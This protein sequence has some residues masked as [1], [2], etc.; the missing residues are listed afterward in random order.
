[1]SA[2]LSERF[3][4]RVV[5][6]TGGAS[7]IGQETVAAFAREGARVA[8]AFHPDHEHN[9]Q[10]VADDLRSEGLDVTAYAAD[11]GDEQ[12]FAE[13]CEAVRDEIG[14]PQTVLA[15]AAIAPAAESNDLAIWRRVLDVNLTGACQTLTT[16]APEMAKAGFGRLLITSS[17]SGPFLAW[18][19]HAAYCASK[20]GLIGL[21]RVL[22][23]ELASSGVTVNAVA[24]GVIRTPQS[25][26]PVNSLGA[27]RLEQVADHVPVGRVGDPSDIAGVFLF[28]A[29]DAAAYLTGQLVVVDGGRTQVQAL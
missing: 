29:S 24:P 6:V 26:D 23:V 11:V 8:F 21:M 25:L 17:T 12:E 7:G 1:V 10:R 27:Q 4:G 28:L 18:P 19:E 15:N 14:T 3:R 16:F 13:V 22:A 20:A 9:G 2:S 5:M